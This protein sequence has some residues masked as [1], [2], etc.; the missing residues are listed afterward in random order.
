[1]ADIRFDYYYGYEGEQFEFYRIPKL[2][3]THSYFKRLSNNAKLLYGIMLDRMGESVSRGWIDKQQRIYIEYAIKDIMTDLCCGKSSAENAV[4]ELDED[5]GI[6]LI[7]KTRQGLG[8][9]NIIYVKNFTSPFKQAP[10]NR[11]NPQMVENQ[12]SGSLNF[13]HQD[14]YN[15]N[16]QTNEFQPS[17]IPN[18]NLLE[19]R[20][21]GFRITADDPSRILG[22]G[23]QDDRISG[24]PNSNPTKQDFTERDI[25]HNNN[26]HIN[27]SH[28]PSGNGNQVNARTSHELYPTVDP[29][30]GDIIF[31][32]REMDAMDA[33]NGDIKTMEQM[34]DHLKE[35][36]G[37]DYI[38]IDC[39]AD[40]ELLDDLIRYMAEYILY[41]T[42]GIMVNGH[43]IPVQVAKS[44]FMKY[45][46]TLM[47]YVM[48]TI[49]NATTSIK[50]V[51]AYY[52][53]ALYNATLSID[54]YFNAL[55]KHDMIEYSNR[56]TKSKNGT[57][58]R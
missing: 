39:P 22:S 41:A 32:A 45:N 11:I 48:D 42:D 15:S 57:E 56:F 36:V 53:A 7:K 10:T 35:Q 19:S 12:S 33:K 28:N 38:I 29:K 14:N 1:M 44:A 30:T 25:K 51:R 6:G 46:I 54:G 37:Y 40:Q 18:N 17:G 47:Q 58:G 26:I 43:K 24:I 34:Q 13:S 4:T 8:R 20:D 3:I 31:T 50:N 49:S 52:L 21:A 16:I 55:V 5:K 23:L 2:L 27:P 9:P